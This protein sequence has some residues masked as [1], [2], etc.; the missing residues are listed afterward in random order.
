MRAPCQPEKCKIVTISLCETSVDVFVPYL[1]NLSVLLDH[2]RPMRGRK[3]SIPRSCSIA[4][5]SQHVRS[6]AAGRRGQPPRDGRLRAAGRARAARVS[7]DRARYRR[8]QI[9][10]RDRDRF[11]AGPAAR[12]DR[13]RRGQGGRLHL[14]E[15]RNAKIHRA[16]AAA[17]VQRAAVLLSRHDGLR[18]PAP[19]RRRSRQEG[20]SGTARQA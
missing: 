1:G 8:A 18:H 12:G 16:V 13:S 15:R 19:R 5:R 10:D 17:D 9:A 11:R 6:D 3:T 14:Q 20:F 4:A 7:G 2:A